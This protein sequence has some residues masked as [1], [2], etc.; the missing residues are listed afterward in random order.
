[1]EVEL[2]R[3]SDEVFPPEDP[4]LQKRNGNRLFERQ[5]ICQEINLNES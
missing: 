2:E 5:I 4:C 3:G 1:M